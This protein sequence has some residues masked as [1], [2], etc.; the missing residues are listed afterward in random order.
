MTQNVFFT[1]DT[2]FGH[3]NIHKFCPKTRLGKDIQEHD[4]ILIREWCN[5]VRSNDIVYHLGDFCFGNS[6]YAES[7][8]ERLTGK[9][10]L[11]WGNHDNVF[12]NNARL[13]Q[14]FDWTGYYKEIT[15]PAPLAYQNI[16]EDRTKTYI[17]KDQ[18]V[19][20]FHFPIYE[21]HKIHKGSFHL[22]GHVHGTVTPHHG[23]ALDVGVDNRSSD[24]VMTLWSWEEVYEELIKRPIFTPPSSN[25]K[26]QEHH[27]L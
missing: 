10:F 13:R 3:R 15:L 14:R 1:S 9:I 12:L 18:K 21:W 20:L 11:I 5:Q 8:L 2:H 6:A 25:H 17:V 16:P 27:D 7:L 23:R 24:K 22:Y 19:V 26:T 4:E